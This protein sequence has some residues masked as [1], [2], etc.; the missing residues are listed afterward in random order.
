MRRKINGYIFQ[1]TRSD[2]DGRHIHVFVDDTEIGVFDR[3][4]GPMR[5]L[6]GHLGKKLR[7]ALDEFI[8][9]LDERSL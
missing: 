5:G 7:E 1:F 9:L 2:H 4:D 6:E 8:A 3:V